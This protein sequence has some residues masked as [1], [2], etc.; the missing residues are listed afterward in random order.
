[1]LKPIALLELIRPLNCFMAAAGALVGY[2]V[3]IHSLDLTNQ[4]PVLLVALATFLVCAGGQ[5]VNDYYDRVVDARK[6]KSKPIPSGRISAKAALAY[7]ILLFLAGILAAYLVNPTAAALAVVFSAILFSYSAFFAGKK[8]F[9]NYLVA[10]SSGAVFLMGASVSGFYF[11]PFLLGVSAVFSTLCREVTKDLEDLKADVG[12]KTTLPMTTSPAFAA[13]YAYATGAL[14]ILTSF[15]PVFLKLN[16]SYLFIALLAIGGVVMLDSLRR[17][18][19]KN[20]LE[21]QQ[22]QKQAM[23]IVLIAY[24]A[25]LV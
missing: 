16:S 1:M 17:I 19:K 21:A 14:A 8:Y 4:T 10:A 25:A 5:A 12:I 7:S 18:S 20:Y 22:R 24:L 23:L 13:K 6:K 9:G 11:V 3:S 15:S 2:F